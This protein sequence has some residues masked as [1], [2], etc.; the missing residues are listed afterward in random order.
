MTFSSA[1]KTLLIDLSNSRTKLGLTDGERIL[2]RRF[3]ATRELDPD[4]LTKVCAR[5]RFGRVILASVVPKRSAWVRETFGDC[6]LEVNAHCRLGFGFDY[7]DPDGV[8]ADRL[9]N[10]AALAH[11]FGGRS[12]AVDFGTAVTFDVMNDGPKG[13]VF[14]GGVIAPGVDVMFDYLHERTALLPHVSGLEKLP[15]IGKSTVHAIKAGAYYG[16]AGMVR[17]ILGRIRVALGASGD[18]PVVGTGGYAEILSAELPE[19]TAVDPDLTLDGLR[20]LANLNLNG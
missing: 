3:L 12:V 15:P 16:S 10:A 18:L 19:I 14:A 4:S 2:E 6:V 1:Q 8:G 17:E 11:R 7:P 9:A 5:W 20:I 13:P